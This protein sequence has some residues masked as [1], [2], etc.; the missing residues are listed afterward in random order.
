MNYTRRNMMTVWYFDDP[1]DLKDGEKEL[2]RY[3]MEHGEIFNDTMSITEEVQ[4]YENNRPKS[5]S[6]DLNVTRYESE[7]TSGYFAVIVKPFG[8]GLENYFIIYYG[9]NEKSLQEE[10]ET[11]KKLM[12]KEYYMSNK[13]G[14]V[15]GLEDCVAD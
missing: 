11:I 15:R 6:L 8:D 13:N 4:K 3:L 12:A 14:F 1:D 7:K 5:G 2:C 9:T 10:S